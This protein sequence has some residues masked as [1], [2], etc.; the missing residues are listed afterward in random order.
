MK[1]TERL[2][3][4][5]KLGWFLQLVLV[6]LFGF[7]ALS[8]KRPVTPNLLVFLGLFVVIVVVRQL[9]LLSPIANRISAISL[10]V[11]IVAQLVARPVFGL[12][13][14][15]KSYS[16]LLVFVV[17]MVLQFAWQFMKDRKPLP[18]K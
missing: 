10:L 9:A 4:D 6:S 12:D 8:Y 16:L 13:L 7:L 14:A 3:L 11:V 1:L 18:E 15:S 17:A 2:T 5:W